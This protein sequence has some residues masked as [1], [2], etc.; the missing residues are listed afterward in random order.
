M[1]YL[2]LLFLLIGQQVGQRSFQPPSSGCTTLADNQTG[3][4][5]E[6]SP[7]GNSIGNTYGAFAFTAGSS[8]TLCAV[9]VP[10]EKLSSPTFTLIAYVYSDSSNTPGSKIGIGSASI[11]TNTLSGSYTNVKFTGLSSPITSGAQYWIVIVS[12]GSPNDYTN[13]V[14]W[15]GTSS[16]C[17]P[18][19]AISAAGSSWSTGNACTTGILATY[20]S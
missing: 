19:F 20:H 16:G 5:N 10:L 8:Y 15:G 12:S 13:Y 14:D 3:T 7:L 9:Q 4:N 17:T 18:Y 6:S 2:I 11:A 1:K